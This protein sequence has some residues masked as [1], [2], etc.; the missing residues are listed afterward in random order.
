MAF[1]E[2]ST[3]SKVG[4]GISILAVL[5]DIAAFPTPYWMMKTL[6][7]TGAL[8]DTNV[9]L[10]QSCS[11]GKI[12]TAFSTSEYIAMGMSWMVAVQAFVFLGF[13]SGVGGCILI[14]LHVANMSHNRRFK[15]I[16]MFLTLA[17]AGVT[18]TGIIIFGIKSKQEGVLV[19]YDLAGAFT[20]TLLSS[21]L[22]LA[23]GVDLAVDVVAG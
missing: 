10:F 22:Y 20:L 13:F 16:S 9:G 15:I 2:A 12:C 14:L 4:L 11:W 19:G 7:V 3:L 6:E 18:L 5:F 23:A 1:S 21:M 8:T 17:A